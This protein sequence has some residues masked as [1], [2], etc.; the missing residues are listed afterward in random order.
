MSSRRRAEEAPVSLFS[1]QDIIMSVSGVIIL[2]VLLLGM[3]LAFNPPPPDGAAE[4]TSPKPDLVPL[5]EQLTES[6]QQTQEEL[7]GLGAT[8]HDIDQK[9]DTVQKQIE[10]MDKS[11]TTELEGKAKDLGTQIAAFL[12]ALD[13]AKKEKSRLEQKLKNLRDK[14]RIL[15]QDVEAAQAELERAIPDRLRLLPPQ[16]KATA[17]YIVEC[18]DRSVQLGKLTAKGTV[19]AVTRFGHDPAGQTELLRRAT[20]EDEGQEL[21]IQARFVFLIKPSSVSYAMELVHKL[22]DEGLKVGY[23]PLE[24]TLTAFWRAGQP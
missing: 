7:A 13:Q 9:I 10:Q 23:D 19:E 24:E 22:R 2:V 4:S 20:A 17:V 15:A 6:I 8:I 18:A 1:L 21:E 14:K 16:D 5:I 3:Q 11:N 12:A